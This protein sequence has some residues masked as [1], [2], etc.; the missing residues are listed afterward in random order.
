MLAGTYDTMAMDSG[1]NLRLSAAKADDRR[2]Q[3]SR[4]QVL[5]STRAAHLAR[6]VARAHAQE[7]DYVIVRK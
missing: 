1:I 2:L 4:R 7:A 5:D 3:Q 6:V